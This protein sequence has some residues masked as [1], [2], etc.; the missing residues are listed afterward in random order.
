MRTRI[1]SSQATLLCAG[2]LAAAAPAF[3]QTVTSSA[4][5]GAGTLREALDAAAP[6]AQIGFQLGGAPNPTIQL[7]DGADPLLVGVDGVVI[8]GTGAPGLTVS[9]TQLMEGD[10]LPVILQLDADMFPSFFQ[11]LSYAKVFS[12]RCG[13]TGR[14]IMG[15]QDSFRAFHNSLSV[16]LP[17][18][19]QCHPQGS[20]R[21][22]LSI[23][24]LRSGGEADDEE[25][26]FLGT[27]LF[28]EP[29]C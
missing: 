29:L 17:G 2:A 16:N 7:P 4:D 13:I 5:S 18:M 9:G 1:A 22:D 26:F 24:D 12:T 3:A 10:P 20:D 8:D 21:D 23:N 28:S 27:Q 14:V 19:Y 11:F 15:D 25:M 6:D